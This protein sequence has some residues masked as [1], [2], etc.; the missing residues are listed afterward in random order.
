M[1]KLREIS[2]N[3]D[4]SWFFVGKDRLSDEDVSEMLETYY[5]GIKSGK[6]TI[7]CIGYSVIK[8]DNFDGLRIV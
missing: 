7:V 8:M 4:G 2:V 5:E 3:K 6:S 1:D